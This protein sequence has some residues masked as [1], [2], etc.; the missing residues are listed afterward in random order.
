MSAFALSGGG[1]KAI[2]QVLYDWHKDI[3]SRPRDCNCPAEPAMP[4]E[5][6]EASEVCDNLRKEQLQVFND[7]SAAYLSSR[8]PDQSQKDKLQ[9]I[10]ES[11][12]E[13]LCPSYPTQPLK[14]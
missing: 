2:P 9:S 7:M 3:I 11:Q 13:W 12:G 10:L 1:T 14:A 6:Q 8:E 4:L 5:R